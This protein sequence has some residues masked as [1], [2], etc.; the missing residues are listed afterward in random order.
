MNN[1]FNEIEYKHSTPFQIETRKLNFELLQIAC[2]VSI[3]NR[4]PQ[5]TTVFNHLKF[6][7]V[8]KDWRR[9]VDKRRTDLK[10]KYNSK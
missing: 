5:S 9:N 3:F 2:V 7:D 8:I 6:S 1:K 4:Y 10:N